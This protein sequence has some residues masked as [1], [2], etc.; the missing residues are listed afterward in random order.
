MT[1]DLRKQIAEL[2]AKNAELSERVKA[3]EPKPEFKREPVEPYD[4]LEK[5]TRPAVKAMPTATPTDDPIAGLRQQLEYI[6]AVRR[7]EQL[8]PWKMEMMR[9]VGDSAVRDIVRDNMRSAAAQSVQSAPPVQKGTGWV[10][11]APL[12]PRPKF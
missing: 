12:G 10:D 4:P 11:P 7:I 9:A 1:E 6:K 3:L 2:Q 5:I 8:E